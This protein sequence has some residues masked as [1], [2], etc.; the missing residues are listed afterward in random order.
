MNNQE[1]LSKIITKR[2]KYIDEYVESGNPL[3]NNGCA[4]CG[5]SSF[6]VRYNNGQIVFSKYGAFCCIMC[7]IY[8]LEQ[9]NKLK[10]LIKL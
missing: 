6:S 5:E 2:N 10:K 7:S 4:F 3:P 8:D 1:D 9:R